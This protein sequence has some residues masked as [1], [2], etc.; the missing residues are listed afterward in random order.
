MVFADALDQD[1][2]FSESEFKSFVKTMGQE[3]DASSEKWSQDFLGQKGITCECHCQP[4]E[5]NISEQNGFIAADD[6]VEE[7]VDVTDQDVAFQGQQDFWTKLE[8][9]WKELK[10]TG[11]HPWLADFEEVLVVSPFCEANL[12]SSYYRLVALLLMR[13]T[14]S[15]KIIS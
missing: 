6:W 15:R 12:T 1:S 9:D 10:E 3:E 2:R 7:F 11:E 5:A 8:S 14:P 13:N 4:L